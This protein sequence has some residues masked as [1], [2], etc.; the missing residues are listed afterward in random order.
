M[1][2]PTFLT[3]AKLAQL[4]SHLIAAAHNCGDSIYVP[5]QNNKFTGHF[6][7]IKIILGDLSLCK[8]AF[9]LLGVCAR[10]VFEST[11]LLTK[12]FYP[13]GVSSKVGLN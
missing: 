12:L 1:K 9:P 3:T 2:S 8:Y 10:D 13:L 6:R 4:L 11:F 7:A 5:L